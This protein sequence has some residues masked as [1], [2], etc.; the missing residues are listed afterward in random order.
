MTPFSA[1]KQVVGLIAW[2]LL[3]YGAS[4]LGAIASIQAKAFYAELLQPAWAPPAWVFGP[5]WTT[6]FTLMAIAAWLVWRQ[7]SGLSIEPHALAQDAQPPHS[8]NATAQ[9]Q[10]RHKRLA[11]GLFVVQL[12]V[13]ALWSWL[14]FAWHLGLFA[15]VDIL[16]LLGLI[17]ATLMAF[18]RVHKV[19]GLLLLPYFLWV[20]FAAILSYSLWQNNP[21]LLG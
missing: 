2:L 14:F 6:L 20:S 13:N 5:M 10:A 11:L 21:S 3:S 4:A 16:M 9:I 12:G 19:A 1:R 8:L 18:Y 15:F 7:P 17:L